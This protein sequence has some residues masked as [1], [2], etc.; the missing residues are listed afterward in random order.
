MPKKLDNLE[1]M[2]KFLVIY[3]LPK[4]NQEES[5]N[6]NRQI[7]THEIEAVIKKLPTN[8]SPRLDA[9]T[10][11]FHQ[12]FKEELT[13]LRKLFQNI[14]EEGR[15]PSS[16]Y[17]AIIILIPKHNKDT[18][19]KEGYRPMSPMNIDIEILNRIL[20]NCICNTLKRSNTMIN[21]DLPQGCN[22][23]TVPTSQ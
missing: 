14:R 6:L 4:V 17:K 3:S 23:G 20:E 19:K 21:W 2:D 7:T 18:T 9:F 11:E 13:P 5:E 12:T 1:E 15:P 10:G 22:V 16:F 8:E